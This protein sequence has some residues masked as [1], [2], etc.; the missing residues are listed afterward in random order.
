MIAGDLADRSERTTA[1]DHS[2]AK[3]AGS[4]YSEMTGSSR[5]LPAARIRGVPPP[6]LDM[7]RYF[8]VSSPEVHRMAVTL[9][10]RDFLKRALGVGG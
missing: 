2:S 10:K 8:K 6:E 4:H 3:S 7:Q 9:E 1:E 5:S